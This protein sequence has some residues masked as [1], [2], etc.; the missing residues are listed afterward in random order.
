MQYMIAGDTF[1]RDAHIGGAK[2]LAAHADI[3]SKR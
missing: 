2:I 3:C 1:E